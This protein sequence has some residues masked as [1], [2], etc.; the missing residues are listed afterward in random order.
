MT[1]NQ[2]Y[3][4]IRVPADED[5]PGPAVVIDSESDKDLLKVL[6]QMLPALQGDRTD[7]HHIIARAV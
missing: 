1:T 7:V 5:G 4:V 3:F 2:R 6:R